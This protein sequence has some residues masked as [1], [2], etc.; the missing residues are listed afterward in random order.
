MKSTLFAVT[1]LAWAALACG[2]SPQNPEP[3]V[4]KA[5]EERELPGKGKAKAG[6]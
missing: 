6:K 2:C 3:T 1:L 5:T 4:I